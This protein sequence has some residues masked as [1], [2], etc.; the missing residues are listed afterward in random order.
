MIR[1]LRIVVL[2]VLAFVL[3]S[4]FVLW[5]LT[6]E[7]R[8]ERRVDY[9]DVVR[10]SVARRSDRRSR[11]MLLIEERNATVSEPLY[12]LSEHD[13]VI[14]RERPSQHEPSWP[15]EGER[16]RND[17]SAEPRDGEGPRRHSIR[18]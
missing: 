8:V 10:Q 6:H 12:V 5:R 2:V 16:C 1:R 17:V 11:E 7:P 15:R 13:G 3:Y 4:L 14:V 18:V 9:D